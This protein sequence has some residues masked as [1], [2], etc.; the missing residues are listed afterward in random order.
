LGPVQST[1]S[2]RGAQSGSVG[3]SL[4]PLYGAWSVPSTS[5]PW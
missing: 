2:Q 1:L 3:T 4:E 5:G